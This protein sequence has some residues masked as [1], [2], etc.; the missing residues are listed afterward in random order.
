M[1]IGGVVLFLVLIFMGIIPGLQSE[2]DNKVTLLMW[3]FE[4][5]KTIWDPVFSE[6]KKDNPNVT[7]SYV[8]KDISTFEDEFVNTIA[9]GPP[10]KQ[11]PDILVFPSE[12]LTRQA[13]KLSAAPIGL[14]TEKQLQENYIDAQSMF[15][16]SK[17]QTVIGLP[18]Y[19]DALVLYSNNGLLTKHFITRPPTTWDEFLNYSKQITEKDASNNIVIAG[20]AMGRAKNIFN[21]PY[22]IST[23]FLQFGDNIIDDNGKVVLGDT[24]NSGEV[25]L[26]PAQSALVFFNDFGNPKKNTYS[27]S[28]SLPEAQD[29]FLSGKAGFYIGFM[30]EY[31]NLKKKNPHL[32][33][34]ISLL[35]QLTDAPR[36]I[37][38]GKL[39]MLVVP[40]AS[41]LQTQSW[42]M[43]KYFTDPAG[44]KK[45]TDTIKTVLP[46]RDVLPSYANEEVR[47]IFARSILS[48]KLWRIP[49]PVATKNV[50]NT[51]IE[52]LAAGRGSSSDVIRNAKTQLNNIIQKNAL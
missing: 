17:A 38:S 46:R 40:R 47:S 7:I 32:D 49:E 35:P 42:L 22:I 20:A 8:Q 5:K 14:V 10:A 37:T 21:A 51:M 52:D 9:V 26:S 27:W 45:F 12:Y 39:Y 41:R 36:P 48:L 24:K 4:D 43:A 29:V 30:S 18:L 28:S 19:G 6:L 13:D 34:T 11:I 25:K 3:G 2:T 33:I 23:L 44:G 16:S 1:G 31:E 50:L 15:W